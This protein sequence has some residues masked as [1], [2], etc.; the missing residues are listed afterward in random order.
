MTQ[1]RR[2]EDLAGITLR[3]LLTLQPTAG[4]E[5]PVWL[6]DG[7]AVLVQ[8]A[9]GGAPAIRHVDVQSGESKELSSGMGSLPFLSSSL[10]STAPNG[11]WISY[12]SDKGAD[13]NRGRS[14]RVEIWLQPTAGGPAIQLTH[15]HA[16]I[17]AYAWAPDSRAI[18]FSANRYGR[19]DIFK[20]NVP[21]G[22]TVRLTDDSRYEVYP[23]FSPDGEQIYYVRLNKTWTDHTIIAMTVDGGESRV[24]AEDGDFFDYHYGRTFGFPL[25]SYT[26]QS[27]LFP[28]HR[29]GWINYWRVSMRGGAVEPVYA[30][31]SDQTQAQISPDGYQIAFVANTNGTTRLTIA[32]VDGT[33]RPQVLVAPEMGV[34]SGPAWSPDGSQIAYLLG[35][36]TC[37]S[38]LWLVDVASGETRQLTASPTLTALQDKLVTPEKVTYRSS[39]G[40]EIAAYLYAPAERKLNGK[41]PALVLVHGGPTSQF[42]DVY[43]DDVQY[44]VRK[45]YVVLLPNIRGSSGY[46]KAFE[47]A[48]NQDWGHGDL[49]DVLAGVDLLKSLDY[50]DDTKMAIHGT[51]YGGCMSMAAVGFAPG[52]FQAAVPHAGYGDWLDFDD[53]Q[54]LRHR[55]LLRYEFGDVKENRHVYRRSSPI[56]HLGDATT[57]VF[58]VHGEGR[59]P[60][61]DASSKFATA[62][63]QEYKTFEYKIYPN[64][65]YYVRS[66]ENLGE[67]YPDIV[68]FLDRYL[69]V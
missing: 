24:V 43:R 3:Q 64:E 38:D 29:N 10:M 9:L 19:Y 68:D 17:N 13:D 54:E 39:D 42:T 11:Q 33:G 62:L 52:V 55:Q 16:N 51:S 65:C 2:D 56:Y 14:S 32:E 57:P 22:N 8:S 63:E 66:A 7:S 45:G 53:E 49:R 23:V 26:R 69:G 12:V 48:N 1:V 50:V 58:L 21:D 6:P 35:T 18:V 44:F 15:I 31:A 34:V 67:M 47:D 41:Y 37:P 60:R 36:P 30:E 28:S 46:G 4:P 25:T 59:Y 40:L 5:P 61:S 20:V 27:I